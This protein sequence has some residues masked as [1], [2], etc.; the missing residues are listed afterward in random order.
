MSSITFDREAPGGAPFQLAG[1]DDVVERLTDATSRLAR[2]N[3][4]LEDFAALVAHEL[5]TPLQ[6]ALAGADP[7][8]SVEQALELVDSLLDAAREEPDG[9]SLTAPADVL[10][11]VLADLDPRDVRVTA[12]ISN[13]FPL[14]AGTLRVILRNLVRNAVA[15]GARTIHVSAS[16][17]SGH[18]T[19]AVD[20]D[21]VGLEDAG[22]Y[23]AGS[24]LGL[25]LS[26]RIADRFGGVLELVPNSARGT[27]ALLVLEE[28]A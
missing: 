19:L 22:R 14:P 1:D 2:R 11:A 26:R 17:G 3:A 24:G 10:D 28:A 27:R 7:T 25:G 15:A 13:S 18:W 9:A 6:A 5:K 8:R 4:A 16:H 23:A 12:D 21:G 20:D